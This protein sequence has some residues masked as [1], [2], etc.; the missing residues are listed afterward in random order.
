MEVLETDAD[1]T[2]RAALAELLRRLAPAQVTVFDVVDDWLQQ[3]LT[4]GGYEL[5][6]EDVLETL[7]FLTSRA[8][9]RR[10]T[11]GGS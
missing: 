5:G 8:V 10:R 1:T 2:G 4:D 9:K 3:D 7:G 6:A 11:S